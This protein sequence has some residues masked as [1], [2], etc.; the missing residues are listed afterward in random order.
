[1]QNKLSTESVTLAL[2]VPCKHLVKNWYKNWRH[3]NLLNF[4]QAVNNTS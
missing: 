1:M 2:K 3:A 4:E